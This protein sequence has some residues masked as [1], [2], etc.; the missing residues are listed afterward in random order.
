M[1]QQIRNEGEC[2]E[3]KLILMK[4]NK[5]MLEEFKFLG[6]GTIQLRLEN[7]AIGLGMSEVKEV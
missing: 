3:F 1:I 5:V 4:F 7:V 2:K 6:I